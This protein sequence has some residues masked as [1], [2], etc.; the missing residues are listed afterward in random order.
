MKCPYVPYAFIPAIFCP[1]SEDFLE[2]NLGFL[3]FLFSFTLSHSQIFPRVRWKTGDLDLPLLQHVPY[4]EER[5]RIKPPGWRV[6]VGWRVEG[7]ILL[8]VLHPVI[9]DG[10]LHPSRWSPDFWTINVVCIEPL[11]G[12]MITRMNVWM[13]N[14]QNLIE[15]LDSSSTA[16]WGIIMIAKIENH[17]I[18]QF[19]Q[20]GPFFC[21]SCLCWMMSCLA[22]LLLDKSIAGKLKCLDPLVAESPR[23]MLVCFAWHRVRFHSNHYRT[24]I[25]I[26]VGIGLRTPSNYRNI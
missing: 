24:M 17:L 5:G 4:I 20:V 25:Q 9:Y 16:E 21:G 6:V 2:R 23:Q 8:M 22:K 10:F 26:D 11:I 14:E 7:D 13:Y 3:L 15:Q 12:I 18:N 1:E 19:V